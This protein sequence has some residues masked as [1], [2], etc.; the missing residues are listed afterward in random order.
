MYLPSLLN[1]IKPSNSLVLSMRP[2]NPVIKTITMTPSNPVNIR[3]QVLDKNGAPQRWVKVSCNV[4]E[5][6]GVVTPSSSY[7]NSDGESFIS[8]FPPT[9]IFKNNKLIKTATISAK[10]SNS[11]IAKLE[12]NLTPAPIVLLHGY[13]EASTVF[14]NLMEFLNSKGYA[15]HAM[16]YDSTIGVKSVIPKLASFLDSIQNKDYLDGIQVNKFTLI[17]HSLGGLISRYYTCSQD[18]LTRNDVHK[19]IFLS[20]PHTGSLM[21]ELGKNIYNDTSILDLNPDSFMF[22]STFPSMINQGLNQ[23]I[24]TGNILGEFDEVVTPEYA[25]LYYWGIKTD[26]FGMGENSITV[27]N[28]IKGSVLDAKNHNGIMNNLK[29]FERISDMLMYELPNPLRR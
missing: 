10:I 5:N 11:N 23:N 6:L 20:V 21:A 16:E 13:R 14:T 18:Y 9:I 12:Y 19:L 1:I 25:S 26:L 4:F 17:G 2:V 29:V 8:Y 28:I 24:Q 27:D 7:T 15:T 22:S 3:I